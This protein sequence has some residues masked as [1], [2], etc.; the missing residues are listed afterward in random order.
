MAP[1]DVF[2][3][4]H[5]VVDVIVAEGSMRR[6]MGGTVAY[7]SFAA[8]KHRARPHIVSKIGLDFPDEYLMSL[9]RSGVDISH[10]QVSRSMP[11]TK[12]KHV[13]ERDERVSY[14][15]TR[16]EDILLGDIPL[17]KIRGSAVIIGA[18]IGEIP[19]DAV[20]EIAER[21][22][23]TVSDL[24]GYVRRIDE[25]RR[26]K[27]VSTPEA[28][29]IIPLSDITH[30]EVSEARVLYGDAEP[31]KLAEKLVKDGAGMSLVTMG[32]GGAYV[33]TSQRVYYVPA[34]KSSE[35]IDRT[36]AGDVFTTVFAI[37]YMNSGDVKEAAAYAAAAVSF[38]IEKPGFNGLRDR[39][40][41][42]GRAEQVLAN[43]KEVV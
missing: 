24:Q 40:E 42:R 15:L 36:G 18:L 3:V 9:S 35:V 38:L 5:L 19:P 30:A 7:G 11:T 26:V 21:A 2:L 28:R 23:L 41:L 20:Q 27:L 32:S 43:V 34:A 12:F 10:I 37:E 8:M 31:P 4:G 1:M 14:L 25:K 13:Y 17:E 39:W 29:L 33:A 6:K 16:C 22:A